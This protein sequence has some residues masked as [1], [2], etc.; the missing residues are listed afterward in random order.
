MELLYKPDWED[1]KK[2]YLAWW[3]H[4]Y[5]GRCAIAVYAPKKGVSMAPP[6][7]PGKLEDRWLDFDYLAAK[8]EHRMRTTF[9]G[10]EAFP[11]WNPGFPGCDGHCTYLGANVT[12]KEETGWIDPIIS[13]GP[14]TD[15]D[16]R[17]L[18]LEDNKWRTFGREV[19]RF[20]VSESKGKSIP[21][22]MAFGA[23]GDTLAAL[24]GSETL[25]YDL[26]ECPEY[27]RDFDLYLMRQWTEIY[28]E[29]YSITRGGA[30]GS[31]CFFT[32]W[33][34]GR[35]Y[36]AQNDFAYMISPKMF[37]E[38]FIPSIEMQT[39]YLD[40]TVYHVDGIGN[41]R[42]VDS[43]LEIGRLQALQILPGAG[44]DSPL[45]FM[46]VLKKVQSA[47]RNLHIGIPAC[48]VKH[49]L[50]Q[51]SARGL[52]IVTQCDTEDE[53]RDLLKCVERW[54]VDRG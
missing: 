35:F 39:R 27:V 47:K 51:L 18:K 26:I 38:I 14:L 49:A 3:D 34:P 43:L 5:F 15:H 44:K 7:L 22:N 53:A 23:C 41:F 11:D 45:H 40:H 29:S 21:S 10:G 16:Y 31:T 30:E 33:S 4:E 46:D 32:L 50:D 8:N 25:L 9:Y 24:R 13:D 42:H 12:L 19:R 36:A 17:H 48:E 52:F 54:S 20:A 37:D 28:E 1:T 2:N 6:P